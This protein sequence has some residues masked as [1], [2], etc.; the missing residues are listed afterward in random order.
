MNVILLFSFDPVILI[1]FYCLVFQT[2]NLVSCDA[3]VKWILLIVLFASVTS[4]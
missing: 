1:L 3:L 4:I 2:L